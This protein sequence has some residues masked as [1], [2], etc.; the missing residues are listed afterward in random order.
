VLRAI[1]AIS[2][3]YDLSIGIA[4]FLFRSQLQ[5]LFALPPPQPPIHADLNAVFVTFVGL[6]YL[7]PLRDPV[8]YRGYLWI[9]GVGL[10]YMGAVAFL[11]DYFYRQS[12]ASFLVFAVS[13]ALVAS[14]TLIALRLRPQ[15]PRLEP[16]APSR[17][18]QAGSVREPA[19]SHR[20]T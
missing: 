9:F 1:A 19:S 13:D 16:Q 14:L 3:V 8:R 20:G 4:L 18:P 10:K 12:P 11:G 17:E 7:L 2:L 15:A 5:T 6:G